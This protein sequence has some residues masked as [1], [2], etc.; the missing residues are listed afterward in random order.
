M[1]NLK[2]IALAM[3]VSFLAIGCVEKTGQATLNPIQSSDSLPEPIIPVAELEDGQWGELLNTRELLAHCYQNDYFP[4]AEADLSVIPESIHI[5][6]NS[7]NA[8]HCLSPYLVAKGFDT[9]AEKEVFLR[10]HLSRDDDF[11]F[12][13][14]LKQNTLEVF[15]CDIPGAGCKLAFLP[16]G[17]IDGCIDSLTG[18]RCISSQYVIE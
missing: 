10:L 16:N 14:A 5:L 18:K 1:L 4:G 15:Q 12:L 3:W 7:I 13:Y 11:L 2:Q 17:D 9:D 8:K 6:E